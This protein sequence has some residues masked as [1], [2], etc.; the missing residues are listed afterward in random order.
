MNWIEGIMRS[1]DYVEDHL[2]DGIDYAE[3]AARSYSSPYHFQRVFSILCGCTLGEYIRCRRLTLAGAELAGGD[4][5]VIDVALKYGYDSPD[6]FAKA[7]QKF[8]GITPSEAR[9]KGS[10][11]RSYSRLS[12]K[13]SLEGGNIMD[14]RIE[15]KEAFRLLGFK[16]RFSGTPGEPPE[17]R[18]KKEADFFTSTRC[19][20]FLLAGM[21]KDS[22]T[23]YGIL[24]NFGED[25]YDFWIAGKVPEDLIDVYRSPEYVGDQIADLLGLE[26]VEIR[27][28]LWLVCE[29]ERCQYPTDKFLFLR[30]EAV[31]NWLPDSGYE[32]RE[33]PEVE[34][35]HW[36]DD[37]RYMKRYIEI[38]L[39]IR[40]KE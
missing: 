34:V 27:A 22:D 9:R 10:M 11:L 19:G 2:A 16:R 13:I 17:T 32:L 25:G 33:G 7:F 15:N 36:Y 29:T 39:P 3:A 40:K 8:H 1:I 5:K 30:Q 31:T 23:Q 6:S 38:W 14:Y 18:A 21:A 4:A 12:V 26:P 24:G 20:Q 37:D 28:G 35:A